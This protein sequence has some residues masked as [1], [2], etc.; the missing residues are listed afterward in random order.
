MSNW[1][2]DKEFVE[3]FMIHNRVSFEI[4]PKTRKNTWHQIKQDI[5]KKMLIEENENIIEENENLIIENANLILENR[6]LQNE[7]QNYNFEKIIIFITLIILFMI[8][9]FLRA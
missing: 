6:R 8:I 7:I 2:R 5:E 4:M 9:M 3:N 1:R